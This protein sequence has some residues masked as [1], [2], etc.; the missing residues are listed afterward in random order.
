MK[1]DELRLSFIGMSGSGKSYWSAR[2]ARQGYRHFCCDALIAAR[3]APELIGPDESRVTMGEWMGFPYQP[4]YAECEAKYLACETAVLEEILACIEREAGGCEWDVIVDTTGS[5]I[6]TGQEL[7]NE[8][9]RY[10]TVVHMAT[11]PEVQERMLELYLANMR[12]VL[13]QGMFEKRPGETNETALARCYPRLLASRERLYGRLA[14]VTVSYDERNREGLGVDDLLQV[15]V[16]RLGR[17][18]GLFK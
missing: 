2:L 13:W 8:L 7:L 15:I 6:Y 14:D 16:E 1:G 3:L 4:R 5:V 10:T 18:S 9:R 11:P 17:A 12:P